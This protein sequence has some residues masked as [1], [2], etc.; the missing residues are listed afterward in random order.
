M[1]FISLAAFAALLVGGCTT[2]AISSRVDEPLVP[3]RSDTCKADKLNCPVAYYSLPRSHV[4][5]RVGRKGML[6]TGE[7]GE[8][9]AA[10]DPACAAVEAEYGKTRSAVVLKVADGRTE[11]VTAMSALL[12]KQPFNGGAAYKVK[13][14]YVKFLKDLK[15]QKEKLDTLQRQYAEDCWPQLEYKVELQTRFDG[16]R[17]SVL[18]DQSAL[19]D[20]TV[21]LTMAQ[22]GLTAVTYASND[23]TVGVV[24]NIAQTIFSI[25]VYLHAGA[26]SAPELSYFGDVKLPLAEALKKISRADAEAFL[27]NPGDLQTTPLDRG[28]FARPRLVDFVMDGQPSV[29][30]P[31]VERANGVDYGFWLDTSCE[32]LAQRLPTTPRGGVWISGRRTCS[33]TL[34]DKSPLTSDRQP[35]ERKIAVLLDDTDGEFLPVQRTRF[36]KR[37]TTYEFSDGFLTTADVKTPS[38]VNTLA[39]APLTVLSAVVSSVT[40]A[41]TGRTNTITAE[42]SN[43]DAQAKLI[44]AKR[45]LE[46]S[47]AG[48]TSPTED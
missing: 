18:L 9:E 26:L 35:I 41:V 30:E 31:I 12:D 8:K 6:D 20:E 28:P 37:E 48:K 25:P 32:P 42:T 44:D 10:A 1:R 16:K 36:V 4:L 15:P 5:I 21:R 27:K 45:K 46:E 7:S 17:V 29:S 22:G 47:R 23:Q 40:N 34:F 2:S 24:S 38:P 39:A 14:D 11:A 33:F 19:A 3:Q 13:A 43:I